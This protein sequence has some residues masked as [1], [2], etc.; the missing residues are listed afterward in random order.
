M[1]VDITLIFKASMKTVKTQNK[2]LG[3]PLS[4]SNSPHN[5][6]LLLKHGSSPC[7]TSDFSSRAREVVNNIGKLKYFLLQHRKYYI[8]AYSH[9]VSE[10]VRMTDTERDQIDQDTQIFMRTC[11]DAIQQL[12]T[13]AHKDIHSPQVKRHREAVL[14]FIG[15]YLKRVCKL[16]SEQRAIRVKRVVDKKI[17]SRLEPEQSNKSKVTTSPERTIQ[18]SSEESEEKL[19][20]EDNRNKNVA[21]EHANFGLRGDGKADELSSEEIQIM[22]PTV[23]Q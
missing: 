11:A 6:V 3:I 15:H 23:K 19:T 7:S 2:V 22:T 18:T 16:Y 20:C 5:D 1:A 10:Y 13:E 21:D 17:L 14:D 4:R 9:V 8:N 12:R